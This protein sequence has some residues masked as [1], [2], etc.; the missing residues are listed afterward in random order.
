MDKIIGLG[1]AGCLFADQLAQY[2]EYTIYKI[3][4]DARGRDDLAIAK[5]SD[6][7][8]YEESFDEEAFEIYLRSIKKGD[9]VVIAL[10]GGEPISGIVLRMMSLIKHAHLNIVYIS[11]DR[12]LLSETEKR[13][14]RIAF[15]VLQEYARSGVLE[16]LYLVSLP[17]VESLMGE[18]S[19]QDYERSMYNLFSYAFNMINYYD[20]TSP[21][22][23][24]SFETNA[25]SRILSFGMS[26]LGDD[27]SLRLFF[28]VDNKKSIHFYYGV[29]KEM[30]D[31]DGSLMNKIKTHVKKHQTE[32][33]STSFSVYPTDF[34][35]I[36]VL[37]NVYS[38]KVQTFPVQ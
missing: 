30:L 36:M 5:C 33:C 7:Q 4:V 24:T 2:P 34:E 38:D 29:P 13:D 23:S 20:H 35:E 8:N 18:V 6:M 22:V 21:V 25:W 27:G 10:G 19:I 9:D 15:N 11:P 31:S 37:C 3:N 28:P 16:K 14:D 12:N 17:K 1:T 32:D 26:S